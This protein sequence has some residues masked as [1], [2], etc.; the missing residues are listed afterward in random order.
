M[1][2]T[3]DHLPIDHRVTVLRDFTDVAGLTLRSG[4]SAIR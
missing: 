1:S 3:I 2:A 4:D